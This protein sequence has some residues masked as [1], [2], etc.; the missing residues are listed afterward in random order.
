MRIIVVYYF[1][2]ILGTLFFAGYADGSH[3]GIEKIL[4]QELRK[5]R[6][7]CHQMVFK[8]H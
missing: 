3:N 6:S 4:A 5:V 7:I 1:D 8:K 2:T